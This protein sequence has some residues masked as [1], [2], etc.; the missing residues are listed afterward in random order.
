MSDYKNAAGVIPWKEG[1]EL[2]EDAIRRLRD[3]MT[4]PLADVQN[5]RDKQDKKWGE[6]NHDPV[7]W[8]AIL[9]EEVGELAQTAIETE[10]VGMGKH[11]G[12]ESIRMEA[13]HVAAVAVA[14]V[15][16]L[17]RDKWR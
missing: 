1:D 2:P 14:I 11:G 13:V 5:E 16:C 10:F 7:T 3:G 8:V 17:D 12:V 6:Q 4:R 15:E 9:M